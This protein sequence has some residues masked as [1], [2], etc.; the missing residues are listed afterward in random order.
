MEQECVWIVDGYIRQQR[1]S[2]LAIDEEKRLNDLLTSAFIR[3]CEKDAN[4]SIPLALKLLMASYT[5]LDNMIIKYYKHD[6]Y[7]LISDIICDRMIEE[8]VSTQ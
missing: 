3:E 5:K 1:K 7:Q 2:N 6:P 4:L 8:F